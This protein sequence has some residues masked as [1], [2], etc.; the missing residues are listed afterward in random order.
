MKKVLT[1]FI[2]FSSI[3]L[4]MLS[5]CKK[6]GV[7][8]VDTG[9][10]SSALTA[11]TTTLVLDR[12]RLNDT[13][14]AIMFTVTAPSYN[15]KAVVNNYLQI[16]AAGDNWKNPTQALL[17]PKGGSQGYSTANFNALLLK[18]NL[19]AATASQ[20]N[21]RVA[22]ELSSDV[23]TYSNVVTL[24]VT[25]FNLTSWVYAVGAYQGWNIS[26]QDSLIS[27]TGNG[28]YTG[29]LNFT[30]GNNS[31]LLTPVKGS[32]NNKYATTDP[33]TQTSATVTQN[34]AN[35][36]TAP[37]TAGQYIVTF[38]S[39]TNTITFAL[40]DYYALIGNDFTGQNWDT[41]NLMK[42]T[43]DLNG[44]WTA[45]VPMIAPSGGGF[46][47]R[48]DGS[49]TNSWGL[50]GTAGILTDAS[51]GNITIPS[52]GTYTVSFIMP[53]TVFGTATYSGAAFP[54]V[55]TTYTITP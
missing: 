4:L 36:L 13:T 53:M 30:A 38:N 35:N 55:T 11:S 43:N 5:A 20:V 48:Q 9:G 37:T 16:D 21:V 1:K 45:T 24:T 32:Y 3:G 22:N 12:T 14:A 6:S 33:T 44:T 19:P 50:S 26:N 39:N 46:K 7:E 28:I 10:K 8:V 54:L 31:F 2:A 49:W 42:Y 47:I 15:F 17:S 18:L 27:A 29:I 23:A 52:A 34:A 25:P 51:G 41:D 40:A